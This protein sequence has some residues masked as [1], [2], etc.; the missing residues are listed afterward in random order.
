MKKL[1]V[2][3]MVIGSFSIRADKFDDCSQNKDWLDKR[4]EKISETADQRDV[5]A[6]VT[7]LLRVARYSCPAGAVPQ[8]ESA[9]N[10]H[11]V[12]GLK[13][14]INFMKEEADYV[15]DYRIPT[16]EI[17]EVAR[18]RKELSD[19][20]ESDIPTGFSRAKISSLNTKGRTNSRRKA[21]SCTAVDNRKPPLAELDAS[22]KVVSNNMRNQDSIGWCYAYAAADLISH[23]TGQSVSAVDVA[24][25]YNEGSWDDF[26]GSDESDMEGGFTASAANA[27]IK[28]G[29]C[30]ESQLPSQDY[31]FSEAS[32]NLMSELK[33]IEGLYDTYYERTTRPGRIYGRNRLTGSAFDTAHNTFKT[34]LCNGTIPSD[35][36]EIFANLNVNEFMTVMRGASSAND[37]ID[38][39]I[40]ES[41]KPRVKPTISL[42]YESDD[43]FTSTN[44]MMNTINNKLNSGDVLGLSYWATVLSDKHDTS[45]GGHASLIVARKFNA[46][47]GSC[48]YMVRNSWGSTCS[49][50]DDAYDCEDGNIWIPEEYLR[51]AMK[52]VTY[53]H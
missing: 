36:E 4:L 30:L 19:L 22:G 33:A 18:A 31:L 45:S 3:F 13:N 26:W 34:Q 23:K 41:C 16:Y 2:L 53:A 37:F 1:F 42:S 11:K 17:N 39:L 20:G 8:I 9:A 29:L 48:D 52:G 47:T 15:A 43:M 21:A 32:Q 44:S 12:R 38:K 35:W 24:N 14:H 28:R 27:A 7:R 51:R 25:A 6:L 40:A 10:A 50:Y 49:N 46:T 5:S